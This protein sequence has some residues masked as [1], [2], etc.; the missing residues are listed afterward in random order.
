MAIFIE[1][2]ERNRQRNTYIE[3]QI[4]D[5]VHSTYE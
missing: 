2:S 5:A 4:Q 3:L 1:A